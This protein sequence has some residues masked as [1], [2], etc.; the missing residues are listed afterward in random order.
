MRSCWL[1]IALVAM[2]CGDSAPV[3]DDDD[4]DD[5]LVNVDA[6]PAPGDPDAEV[7]ASCEGLE[8]QP[9]DAIWTVETDDGES[10]TTIGN[11]IFL[12]DRPA[13]EPDRAPPT[14]LAVDEPAA[15]GLGPSDPEGDGSPPWPLI[16]AIAVVGFGA[17][18]G[19]G[20]AVSRRR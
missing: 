2:A 8:T 7:L 11:P 19:I 3:G 10:L 4:D 17:A 5:D 6:S 15:A 12:A 9:L 13:P 14:G 18:G 1:A 20:L 16:T